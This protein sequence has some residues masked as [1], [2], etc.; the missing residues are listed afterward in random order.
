MMNNYDDWDLDVPD[1]DF[2]DW[3]YKP[4]R[5]PEPDIARQLKATKQPKAVNQ[6]RAVK[7][8]IA[9]VERVEAEI[10]DAPPRNYKKSSGVQCPRC[11]D[12]NIY[13]QMVETGSKTKRSGTGMIGNTYNIL[14]MIIGLSTCG[15]GFFF[16]PRAQG[17]NKTKTNLSKM[18]IC[19]NCGYSWSIR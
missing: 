3:D 18:A 7:Q 16:M 2:D 9:T 17:S 12:Y 19:Q 15:I 4:Q 5:K 6:P 10:V 14:R 1:D 13:V 11:H 8:P